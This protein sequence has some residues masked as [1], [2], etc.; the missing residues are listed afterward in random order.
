MT[1][2]H[3]PLSAGKHKRCLPVGKRQLR[4][5]FPWFGGKSRVAHLVWERFGQVRNYVEPF[6]GSGAILLARPG[7]AGIETVND[8]DAYL[9]NF[10]RAVTADPDEV[11]RHADWPVN[12]ADL[13][14]RH[15]WLVETAA[16]RIERCKTEPEYFDAKVAG[17]WVWGQCLWIGSGWCSRPEWTGRGHAGGKPRG[18]NGAEFGKLPAIAGRDGG[19]GAYAKSRKRDPEWEQRPHLGSDGKGQGI[20]RVA[21]AKTRKL[22][23]VGGESKGVNSQSIIRK[24]PA[25]TGNG[26]GNGVH[27]PSLAIDAKRPVLAHG[28]GRGVLRQAHQVPDLSGDS[29]VAGRGIHASGFLERS[30]GLQSYM[31]ALADRLRR[32]RVC[33]GDFERILG[34]AVT[35]CIGL[36][37][38]LLDPPYHE[39]GRAI[40]YSQDGEGAWWR[41]R[42][43]AIENGND[44]LL[45]IAL[46]GYEHPDADFP[47]G[48]QAI[49]WKAS[50][51][52]ARSARGKANAHR[53]RILFSPHCLTGEQSVIPGMEASR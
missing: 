32:V 6:F 24:R 38:V 25:L 29:G 28:G 22:P 31:R 37:G 14:A 7:D 26:G 18:I 33:C 3:R 53:E 9:S 44:P 23:L 19:R 15:R 12:E 43:W 39:D 36:T 41:A 2:L 45:R 13:H 46:C 34:P 52:Y 1:T 21:G 42:R 16:E 35:T 47:D 10:W 20:T 50:G 48:W 27:K 4:A 5:P 51:G 30:G 11:A 17:W 49:A 40:C 8:A